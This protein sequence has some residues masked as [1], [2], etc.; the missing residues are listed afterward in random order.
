[1]ANN[2]YNWVHFTGSEE[3]IKKLHKK[4]LDYEKFEYFTDWGNHVLDITNDTSEKTFD[5]CYKYGTKWWDFYVDDFDIHE[6]SISGDT[7]WSPPEEL[8]EKICKKY[9]LNARIEFEECGNDFGGYAEFNS[10]GR[11]EDFNV[12]YRHWRY[13]QDSDSAIDNIIDDIKY[14]DFTL[15]DFEDDFEYM[16]KEDVEYIKKF[17]EEFKN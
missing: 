3:S 8:I 7:A 10:R 17:V 4:F 2:C 12:S 9:S 5:W 13:L 15:E 16:N 1:M 6:L 11:T 14:S